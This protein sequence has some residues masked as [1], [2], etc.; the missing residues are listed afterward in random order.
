[1]I[2]RA[3]FLSCFAVL[4]GSCSLVHPQSL[5]LNPSPVAF[6]MVHGGPVSS[7][8]R[9]T[10]TSSTSTAQNW[11]ATVP[12]DTPWIVLSATKG[13]TPATVTIELVGWRAQGQV[14]GTYNSRVAFQADGGI[15]SGLEVNWTVV[16]RLPAP[17]FSALSGPAGCT[18]PQGYEDTA[19]CQVPDEKPPGSFTP[20]GRGRSYLDPNFGSQ[21]TVLTDTP[22]VHMYS[23]P[24]PV[25]A[26]GKYVMAFNNMGSGFDIVTSVGKTRRGQVDANASVM[27]DANDDETYYY[28]AESTIRKGNARNGRSSVL[29]DYSRTHGFNLIRNGGTGDITKD[30]W[31]GFWAPNQQRVCALDIG[32]Q[33][34]YCAPLPQDNLGPLRVDYILLTKGIDSRTGKRYVLLMADPMLAVYSI[35]VAAGRLDLEFRGPENPE[36]SGNHDNICDPGESCLPSPHADTMEDASGVQYLVATNDTQSPCERAVVTY[37]IGKGVLMRQPVEIGGG[38]KRIFTLFLCGAAWTGDHIGCAR[39]APMCAVSTEHLNPRNP[40]D[41]TPIQRTPHISQIFVMRGNGDEVRLLAQTRSVKFTSEDSGGYWSSTRAS[42]SHDGSFVIADTNFGTPNAH[43]VVRID[44][45]LAKPKIASGGLL[46]AASLEPRVAPGALAVLQGSAL[47]NCTATPES[48]ALPETLCGSRVTINDRPARLLFSSPDQVNL[49]VP[50]ALDPR[51]GI[52]VV[53]ARA[54]IEDTD[55]VSV[56]AANVAEAAPAIFFYSLEGEEAPRAVIQNG[57][58]TVNGPATPSAG[59]RPGRLGEVQV[60]YAN[61]LGPLDQALSDSDPSPLEPLARTQKPAEVYVNDTPQTVLFSG[62]T[63]GLTGLFQV[64]FILNS[65]TPIRGNGED[66]V[67]VS[68]GGV[69]S[70]RLILSIAAGEGSGEPSE[71]TEN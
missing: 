51:D 6:R 19:L 63:P 25:S 15:S 54:G 41:A 52:R 59:L 45:G 40:A 64:N 8:Q 65:A 39:S 13:T 26:T 30:N 27:W 37:E 33:A 56:P 61:A 55:S 38:K 60:L 43:R 7:L 21:V 34:T 12:A 24:S 23:T 31:L 9:I 1:M 29:L 47:A 10:I 50:R 4:I 67:W 48:S 14:P 46:N 66:R 22:Y 69:D 70:P 3:R 18:Q 28:L 71:N 68:M 62:L 53:L 58:G 35:N 17:K 16:P 36:G 42:L 49:L 32:R 44:T 20:P 57:D 11:T 2:F 5:T